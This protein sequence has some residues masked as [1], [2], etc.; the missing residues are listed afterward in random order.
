MKIAYFDCFSGISGDMTLGALIDLGLD[1]NLL[2][3][4]LKK[5]QLEGYKLSFYKVQKHG[6]T[7]TKA[8]VEL[9]HHHDEHNHEH[10]H[11][12]DH[13]NPH[14]HKKNHEH[15]HTR[16]LG[17]IRQLI[18]S[19]QM[20][21]EVK[22]K[23]MSIFTRLGEAEAKIHGVTIDQ[24]HF[25][26]VGA[27]DSI[28]DIVGSVIGISALGIKKVYSSPLSLGRGM[29]K[30]SHGVIP[31][32][33][34]ATLELLKGIPV[35]QTEI[36]G[37][38][39]T[40]TGAAI[41][42]TLAEGFGTM[43]EMIIDKISYGAGFKDLPEQPNML[44]ICLGHTT[45][46]FE[47][48][49]IFVAETNIDDMSPQIYDLL[50]DKL[51][52]LGALDVFLTP[53]LMKKNRPANKLTVLVEQQNLQKIHEC[54]LIETTTMGVRV[55]KADRKKLSRQMSEVE[56]EYG[57]VRVKLGKIG[58]R[59]IKVLPEYDDC[60]RLSIEKG[61]PFLKVQQAALKNYER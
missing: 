13:D 54:I 5:L 31:I 59:V 6:I 35:K 22:T 8:Q 32:P 16:N 28:I 39:V 4:E 20:D 43:P 52:V 60:K 50:I 18:T 9:A 10:D 38:L 49:T 24:V 47:S 2:E 7:G 37:E 57:K 56:T 42:S 34:P 40:P 12:N 53:I 17:D 36:K 25:H 46:K 41:I 14:T 27:V 48:D 3:A 51:L 33:A 58:E 23:S 15:K 61:V 1:P 19:S 26:E 44:R 29:A 11:E 21:E 45:S 30:S 55:Y